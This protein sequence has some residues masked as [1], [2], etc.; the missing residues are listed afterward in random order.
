MNFLDLSKASE[1]ERRLISEI[2]SDTSVVNINKAFCLPNTSPKI[3]KTST[4]QNEHPDSSKNQ[5]AAAPPTSS[6]P[7]QYYLNQ[8]HQAQKQVSLVGQNTDNNRAQASFSNSSSSSSPLTTSSRPV[9]IISSNQQT[10]AYNNNI[11]NATKVA[12]HDKA[13]KNVFPSATNDQNVNNYATQN[14]TANY[15]NSHNSQHHQYQPNLFRS[16]QYYNRDQMVHINHQNSMMHNPNI[17]GNNVGHR[18][19]YSRKTYNNNSGSARTNR[20]PNYY[21]TAANGQYNHNNSNVNT[22][23]NILTEQQSSQNQPLSTEQQSNNNR[24]RRTTINNVTEK[25]VVNTSVAVLTDSNMDQRMNTAPLN[26]YNHHQTMHHSMPQVPSTKTDP[27]TSYHNKQPYHLDSSSNIQPASVV[28]PTTQMS[29]VTSGEL[30]S[31]MGLD[32]APQQG[33]AIPQHVAYPPPP[34]VYGGPPIFQSYGMSYLIP[35]APQT[36]VPFVMPPGSVVPPRQAAHQHTANHTSNSQQNTTQLRNHYQSPPHPPPL[37]QPK[38]NNMRS[39]QPK[40]DIKIANGQTN[41][42]KIEKNNQDKKPDLEIPKGREDEV[43]GNSSAKCSD[44]IAQNSQESVELASKSNQDNVWAQA[45]N[46]SWS[47]LFKHKSAT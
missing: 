32:M 25:N 42:L 10:T 14:Q 38:R 17:H 37:N 35:Y 16:N 27:K 8:Q 20:M 21:S 46:K 24:V 26:I 1:E 43:D 19:N 45:S 31:V 47:D 22:S 29:T 36:Y 41:S 9:K 18:A 5:V 7:Q 4:S 2:L 28:P 33:Y 23:A 12:S 39:S 40:A 6:R 30:N 11:D 15:S 44:E 3:S 13:N 34:H